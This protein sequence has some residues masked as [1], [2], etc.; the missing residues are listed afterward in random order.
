M[1]DP[2]ELFNRVLAQL[3]PQAHRM[4]VVAVELAEGLAVCRVPLAGNGNHL[5]SMYAGVLFTVAEV[6]GGA[7]CLP[8]FDITRFAPVVEAVRID[9]RKQARSDVLA[10]ARL[11][12]ETVARVRTEAEEH[13]RSAFALTAELVDADSVVV[14]TTA[15]DYQLR[16]H[17][18]PD[19]TPISG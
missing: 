2:A 14:A 3:I 17:R 5:G 13:G 6:L 11:D 9:F 12:R 7:I 15:G 8:S 10:T 19:L 16:E 18:F 1:S 4:G